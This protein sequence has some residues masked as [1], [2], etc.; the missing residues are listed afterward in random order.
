MEKL[1][2]VRTA[3]WVRD[4]VPSQVSYRGN[5]EMVRE[6][7]TSIENISLAERIWGISVTIGEVIDEQGEC[8][9]ERD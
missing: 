6:R 4:V 8:E 1:V 7:R 3:G 5:K 9:A 2:L